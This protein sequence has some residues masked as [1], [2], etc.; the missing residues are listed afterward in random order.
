MC[1]EHKKPAQKVAAHAQQQPIAKAK[2][3]P[4]KATLKD[5]PHAAPAVKAKAAP[6][7]KNTKTT[8]HLRYEDQHFV[9]STKPVWNYSR[10]TPEDLQNL[11]QGTLYRGYDLFGA[12]A[13]QV[14]DTDGY[15]FA[16]WAPNASSV[17]VM[18]DFNHWKAH[19]HELFVR[20]DQ[21]GIW[22]GVYSGRKKRTM[23]I[24]FTLLAFRVYAWIKAIRMLCF[25]RSDLK[26]LRWH[27]AFMTINGRIAN[28]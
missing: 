1:A 3:A 16:V 15:Y 20:L 11:H 17:S 26:Q 18:G 19:S 22:E 7:K 24:S 6:K 13:M 8:I 28:G 14:L 5:E 23:P 25:G 4:A 27:G 9:D 21:S 2:K 10:F 12:H